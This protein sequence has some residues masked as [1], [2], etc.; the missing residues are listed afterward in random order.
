MVT[1]SFPNAEGGSSFIIYR[2][3]RDDGSSAF[4][5]LDTWSARI[6]KREAVTNEENIP[7][8]KIKLPVVDQNEWD[9]N[10]YNAV[11]EDTYKLEEVKIPYT[12]NGQSYDDCIVINQ[13]DNGDLHG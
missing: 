4:T 9:G 5:Y 2:S 13:N 11:G 6:D 8:L 1:D 7:F 12:A 3:K 10:L